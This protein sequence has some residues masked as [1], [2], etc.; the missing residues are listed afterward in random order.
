MW[1]DSLCVRCNML[2]FLLLLASLI[3]NGQMQ[4]M[5][6]GINSLKEKTG[7]RLN[8]ENEQ[9]FLFNN[10]DYRMRQKFGMHRRLH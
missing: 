4:I 7:E 9:F 3:E 2:H 8:L 6:D 10:N 1:L 5:E